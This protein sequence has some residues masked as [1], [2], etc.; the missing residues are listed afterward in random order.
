MENLYSIKTIQLFGVPYDAFKG[1][2]HNGCWC[3]EDTV[4]PY[5]KHQME[6]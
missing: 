4:E 3:L 5:Q 2:K 6:F 1:K